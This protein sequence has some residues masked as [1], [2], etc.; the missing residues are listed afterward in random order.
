M[1]LKARCS[2]TMKPKKT[3]AD[4]LV[5][6][7][8]LDQVSNLADEL[9][10]RLDLKAPI[11]PFQIVKSEKPFIRIRGGDLKNRCD[12]KLKYNKLQNLFLLFFNNK[13]DAG[14]PDGEHHARTRFSIG[15]ELGH[16]FIPAHYKY[17]RH[18]GKPHPSNSEYRTKVQ[19]EQEADTFAASLLLP[20]H[21]VKPI[22]DKGITLKRLDEVA[23]DFQASL[24]CTTIRAVRL[25]DEPCAVVG[26]RDGAIAWMF[27][28]ER[29]I[30]A[31]CY[32]GKET[33]DSSTAFE[34]WE[35]FVEGDNE[36]VEK[37]GMLQ[38]WF[39]LFS[40]EHDLAEVFVAEH[41]LPIR[42]M[43][44]LVVLIT[45]EDDDLFLVDDEYE[46]AE[47]EDD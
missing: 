45:V 41:Y 40:K 33:L 6:Q 8:R 26:I 39:Q 38:D 15:H 10:V 46:D 37:E 44:T 32:P 43:N 21:L 30:E 5:E 34:R 20:T 19:M 24:L 23:R 47:S 42:I 3:K 13:Y 1:N 35:A 9:V 17:L 12:G 14:L 22:I 16:Y 27:P 11:D 28:S 7:Q 2:M 4:W 18:G 29:L 25:S 31:G 36:R